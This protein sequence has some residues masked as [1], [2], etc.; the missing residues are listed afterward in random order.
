MFLINT[1]TPAKRTP[2]KSASTRV[3][4]VEFQRVLHSPDVINMAVH[5]RWAELC[6]D[7]SSHVTLCSPI[8]ARCHFYIHLRRQNRSKVL[9]ELNTAATTV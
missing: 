5:F 9:Y 1:K 3:C 7:I 4:L 8:A 6:R 2:L